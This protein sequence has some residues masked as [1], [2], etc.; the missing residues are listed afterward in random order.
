MRF[1][2]HSDIVTTNLDASLVI[3]NLLHRILLLLQLET[4]ICA[5]SVILHLMKL[6]LA[7]VYHSIFMFHLLIAPMQNIILSGQAH[8]KTF[9][10]RYIILAYQKHLIIKPVA[11]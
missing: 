2:T 5:Q 7:T 1:L 8:I 6:P 11:I 9:C 3:Q 4:I 10:Q